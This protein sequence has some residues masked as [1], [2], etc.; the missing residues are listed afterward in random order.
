MKELRA[1]LDKLEL[2][3]TIQANSYSYALYTYGLHIYG[4]GKLE[5]SDKAQVNSYCL[6][7][8]GLP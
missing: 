2:S 8:Y 3:D 4:I 6:H 1:E 5:L 7:I